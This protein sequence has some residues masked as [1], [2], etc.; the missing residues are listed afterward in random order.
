MKQVT[1]HN[2]ELGYVGPDLDEGTYPAVFYF[3]LSAKDSLTI[4]P[5]CQPVQA[6]DLKKCCVF[7]ITLPEHEASKSPHAA[8]GLWVEN[9]VQGNDLLMPFFKQIAH[10]IT[11][12]IEKTIIDPNQ[13]GLMGLSRGAFVACHVAA[14]LPIPVTI[15]GFSPLTRLSRVRELSTSPASIEA[16]DLQHVIP[17]LLQSK[18]RFFIGNHDTRVST[19]SC[20]EFITHLAHQAFEVG[21]KSPPIELAIFPS[22]GYMGHGTPKSIFELGAHWLMRELLS[23]D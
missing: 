21:I 13:F 9:I 20:A 4:D 2:L 19:L 11:D 15:V 1:V 8:I 3:A 7:S 10:V 18:I 22:I 17:H 14:Q 12:L 23:H 6:I 5:Y 16:L